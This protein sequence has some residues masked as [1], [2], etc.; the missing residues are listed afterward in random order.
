MLTQVVRYSQQSNHAELGYNFKVVTAEDE[1]FLD[2]GGYFI[3]KYTQAT[4]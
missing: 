1:E 2:K 3:S 4:A